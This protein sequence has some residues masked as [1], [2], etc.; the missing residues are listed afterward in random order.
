MSLRV[1]AVPVHVCACAC[2][3]VRVFLSRLWR[4]VVMLLGPAVS[5]AA[6]PVSLAASPFSPLLELSTEWKQLRM[7]FLRASHLSGPNFPF[8]TSVPGSL[9]SKVL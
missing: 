4:E 5:C 2:V 3:C 1:L 6:M 7:T 8:G 9:F